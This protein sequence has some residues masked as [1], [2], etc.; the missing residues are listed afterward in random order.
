MV[1]GQRPSPNVRGL[2]VVQ[3]CLLQFILVL[4]DHTDVLQDHADR[5]MFSGKG[6]RQDC[7]GSFVM[8][9]GSIQLPETLIDTGDVAVRGGEIRMFVGQIFLL[10]GQC[11][12]VGVE[13]VGISLLQLIDVADVV[14]AFGESRV[15]L[16]EGPSEDRHGSLV[17]I[18]GGLIIS[19]LSMHDADAVVT[20]GQV[21][22]V[23]LE[24]SLLQIERFPVPLETGVVVSFL[25][26][27]LSQIVITVPDARMILRQFVQQTQKVLLGI[28]EF[29]H[30]RQGRAE[31]EQIGLS[32]S[33]AVLVLH[34]L[35]DGVQLMVVIAAQ[36]HSNQSDS[37]LF[38]DFQQL[39]DRAEHDQH[40][41]FLGEVTVA[42]DVGEGFPSLDARIGVDGEENALPVGGEIELAEEVQRLFADDAG[43]EK[44]V[45]RDELSLGLFQQL[46]FFSGQHLASEDTDGLGTA[47]CFQLSFDVAEEES[48]EKEKI[49]I[50]R[51][52][53]FVQQTIEKRL[54]RVPPQRSRGGIISFE[55]P[56]DRQFLLVALVFGF[57]QL[58]QFSLIVGIGFHSS[59]NVDGHF[60]LHEGPVQLT[61]RLALAGCRRLEQ[62]D[63]QGF[64]GFA[65]RSP[66][67][68]P[69]QRVQIGEHTFD[70]Q[71]SSLSPPH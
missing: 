62:T 40:F 70:L 12:F 2:L 20:L 60:R 44:G 24:H 64:V 11:S 7:Q 58:D 31:G 27:D 10:N 43:G 33:S 59:E 8:F 56:D 1:R 30:L 32:I 19:F 41:F 52:Q 49:E 47:M 26:G 38:R 18:Q 23:V 22:I 15:R 67:D 25:C 5:R 53:S 6:L 61:G 3:Q 63:R 45:H 4:V 28:V 65:P 69:E 29:A 16:V 39:K 35:T 68:L 9:Q 66:V 54:S 13:G 50:A 51:A 46:E 55:L 37:S 57:A 14:K 21:R 48:K 42:G 71:E 34:V 36:S 17:G